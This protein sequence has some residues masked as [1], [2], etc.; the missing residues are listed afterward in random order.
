MFKK[1]DNKNNTKMND[2]VYEFAYA[3]NYSASHDNKNSQLEQII[4]KVIKGDIVCSTSCFLNPS[5]ECY[6][7]R[8]L[9]YMSNN[10]HN[11]EIY[12]PSIKDYEGEYSDINVVLGLD[13]YATKHKMIVKYINRLMKQRGS[14][15]LEVMFIA[16][17]NPSNYLDYDYYSGL[18]TDLQLLGF[19]DPTKE[20]LNFNNDWENWKQQGALLSVVTSP[21]FL[22]G[23]GLVECPHDTEYKNHSLL[24][25]AAW[26]RNLDDEEKK[27][28]HTKTRDEFRKYDIAILNEQYLECN[29]AIASNVIETMQRLTGHSENDEIE[30]SVMPIINCFERV[31]GILPNTE[32]LR[33]VDGTHTIRITGVREED[34][35]DLI[36]ETVDKA[37]EN[38]NNNKGD[39]IPYKHY[40]SRTSYEIIYSALLQELVDYAM[41]PA[42]T[43]IYDMKLDA[44]YTDEHYF[45]TKN[46][47]KE[48]G[49]SNVTN[50]DWLNQYF[51]IITDGSIQFDSKLDTQFYSSSNIKS[52]YLVNQIK[53]H[54]PLADDNIENSF[55]RQR[56]QLNKMHRLM[57]YFNRRH[58]LASKRQLSVPYN[59][60]KNIKTLCC[61][62]CVPN[63][64]HAAQRQ[65]VLNK[66]AA[67]VAEQE[68]PIMQAVLCG[69]PISDVLTD[70]NDVIPP[71]AFFDEE[72]EQEFK[73]LAYEL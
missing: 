49:Y 54:F 56:Q 62:R 28:I 65:E 63:S 47:E 69:V 8:D 13:Y 7:A 41:F 53:K 1:K 68:A 24:N 32:A 50:S 25:V 71:E 43:T 12:L 31:P 23:V 70:E 11:A 64:V 52:L 5:N 14:D 16:R 44:A 61:Y 38:I 27:P 35:I 40:G 46:K 18:L 2:N 67:R 17:K 21:R 58:M 59:L 73:K 4:D 57:Q 72:L 26:S 15:N 20:A 29:K 42:A 39:T 66:L 51:D 33:F 30:K 6:I 55:S 9:E 34:L 3:T 36:A 60:A 19:I 37:I 48:T 45:S 22:S 10:E